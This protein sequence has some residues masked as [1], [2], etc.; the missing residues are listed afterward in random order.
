M[1]IILMVIALSVIIIPIIYNGLSAFVFYGT[2]EFRRVEY[3]IF[4]RGDKIALDAEIAKTNKFR[5]K[6]YSYIDNFEKEIN[7]SPP[8]IKYKYKPE[9]DALKSSLMYLFGPRN[10][11][12]KTLLLRNTYGQTRWSHCLKALKEIN[13]LETWDYSNPNKMGEKVLSP[14]RTLFKGT[15]LEPVFDILTENNLKDMM[16]PKLT[17]YWRFLTDTSHDAYFFGGIWAAILGTIYLT[18]GAMIFAVPVG[19]ISAIYLSEYA[20]EGFVLN[21]IRS[22][23]NTLAGVPSIVFGLFGLAFFI[24]TLELSKSKSVLAGSATLALLILPTI[25]RAAEEA[26][27]S[28]AHTYKEA[29]IGLGASKWH[30]I[31]KIIIPTA[32]PGILTGIVLSMGRAAGE[33]A[34]IIFTAAVSVGKPLKLLDTLTQPTQALSWNIYNL[35]T[36]HESVEK[37]RHVQYGMVLVL[38]SIVLILNATAIITRARISKKLKGQK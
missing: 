4:A 27:K 28:V 2:V 12:K 11:S 37:I 5:D 6:V 33:T 25:I 9:V 7:S 13:Y 38:L 31:I 24:N 34:P 17:F 29:S 15:S 8:A 18:I 14:R 36:E 32:L 19:I 16:H 20:D 21:L 3:D 30:T 10:K 26:I 35:C 22:C 23:I 1:S